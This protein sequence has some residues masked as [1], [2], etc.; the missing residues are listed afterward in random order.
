MIDGADEREMPARAVDP[1]IVHRVGLR[2]G[3]PADLL[4]RVEIE[5][6]QLRRLAA[7]PEVADADGLIGAEQQ[8][9]LGQRR[10]DGSP[11]RRQSL[12]VGIDRRHDQIDL[13]DAA[14]LDEQRQELG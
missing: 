8:H 12:Q 1:A 2:G 13:V 14:E 7:L 6:D 10:A 4:Q 5:E 3:D 9:C 11:M